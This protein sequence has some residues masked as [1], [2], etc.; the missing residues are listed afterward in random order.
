MIG[1]VGIGGLLLACVSQ[2]EETPSAPANTSTG[3]AE[4][5][6]YVRGELLIGAAELWD[7]QDE[8]ILK[9]VALVPQDEYE[10]EHIRRAAQIDWPE[11][12]VT[13]TSDASIHAWRDDVEQ[14]LGARGLTPTHEVVVYDNGTVFATRLWWLLEYLG[15]ANNRVLNGGL[16]AWEDREGTVM[17]DPAPIE[18]STYDGQ[19]NP[20][21]LAQLVDV[22][23]ML[24][25]PEVV[26]VD[27]RSSQEY[28]SGH[29]PGAINIPWQLNV[30]EQPPRY[31][32]PQAELLQLYERGGVVPEK[33]IIPY[34]TTGVFSSI[35]FFTLRLI[36]YDDVRLF[37]GSWAEWSSH[38][39][40]PIE[41]G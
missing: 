31:W 41:R 40:L 28:E 20:D 24:D 8:E 11:L 37:T 17:T 29:I 6:N 2:D 36:G 5:F 4:S 26:I 12:K 39:E 19:P 9:I 22:Q 18:A 14:Q 7:R 10:R 16:A 3:Q 33:T 34:C 30:E 35:T 15:H 21:V 23:A 13:D 25:N 1:A 38:P 32:K 27:V